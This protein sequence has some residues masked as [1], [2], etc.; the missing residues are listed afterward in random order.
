LRAQQ[1]YGRNHPA[2][3]GN[4]GGFKPTPIVSLG[5][6]DARLWRYRDIPAHVYGPFPYGM[7]STDENPTGHAILWYSINTTEAGGVHIYCF[8]PGTLF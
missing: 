1:H 4:P 7:G 2:E 8:A 5:G 3:C 6:T